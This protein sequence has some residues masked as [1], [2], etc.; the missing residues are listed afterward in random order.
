MRRRRAAREPAARETQ[1]Q[2]EIAAA[3]RDGTKRRRR[4]AIA[5]AMF[6]VAAV[7]AITHVFAHAGSVTVLAQGWQDLLL[8]WPMAGMIAIS[9]AI[10]YGT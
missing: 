6:T 2:Q 5:Y 9:G 7:M 10:V 1:R 8:G 4:H 3:K